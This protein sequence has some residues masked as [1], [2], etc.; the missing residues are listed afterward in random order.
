MKSRRQRSH[1]PTAAD[2]KTPLTV[3]AILLNLVNK[4]VENCKESSAWSAIDVDIC[5]DI[6]DT[7]K[8][9]VA[10]LET[11]GFGRYYSILESAARRLQRFSDVAKAKKE[12]Y[13]QRARENLRDCDALKGDLATMGVFVCF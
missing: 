5:E 1:D 11:N 6:Y 3:Y 8:R 9:Q 13:S 10:E 2:K 7:K 4:R 12:M